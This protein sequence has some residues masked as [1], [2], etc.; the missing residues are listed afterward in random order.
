V[1]NEAGSSRTVGSPVLLGL[2]GLIAF[3]GV[4]EL[5]PR[6]GLVPI[7]YAP[8]P[9]RIIS[10]LGDELSQR[11]FW[12]A[13]ADTIRTWATGLAIAV[14]AGLVVG[15]VIGAVPLLR[16]LT[17]STIEF[18]RP[19]PSVVLIPL[20]VLLYPPQRA[21]VV[22]VVYAAF[23]QMLV[24]VLHGVADI[25]PV[26]LDTAHAY[27]LGRWT[28]VRYLIWPTVLPYAATGVRLATA[29]ALIL[30]VTG[31]MVIGSPGLGREITVAN[32]SDAVPT[33]YAL[34]VV[35][36]VLGLLANLLT[37]ATE[38]R[39]LAWHPSVRKEVPV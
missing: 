16:A 20:V 1:T 3:G 13:L 12:T 21:T 32:S 2:L 9:S 36:G 25:D 33:M 27:H 8:P 38:R 19:I 30:T 22:L 10:A 26:A 31:Q 4:L 6:T 18:L 24:Q 34:I 7:R 29:V 17:A 15:V 14:V 37:R 39:V 5:V 11:M 28:R 23:W 35:T